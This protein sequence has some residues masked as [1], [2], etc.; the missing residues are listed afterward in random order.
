MSIHH[1]GAP[2]AQPDT[3]ASAGRG[4]WIAATAFLV[5]LTEQTALGFTLIAPALGPFAAKY[6]TTQIAWMIT[7]FILVAAVATPVLGKVADRIGKKR[8]LV[9]AGAIGFAGSVVC[10]L[11]PSYEVMLLGRGLMGV[12]GAFMPLAYA[13]IRDVFPESARNLSIGIVTNGVG[14]VTIAGPFLAGFLIDNVSLE[15]VFWFVAVISLVGAVGT[16]LVVPESPYRNAAPIDVPGFLG[17]AVGLLALM[18]GISNLATWTLSDSRTLLFVGGGLAILVAWWGWER[19]AAHP[20]VDTR[21][22]ASRPV[23]TVVFAYSF[24]TAA[25]TIASSYLPT[26]LQTPRALGGD[27]GFGL[28]ATGVA[29]YLIPAGILT[30]LAG[31][32]V[33]LAA[34]RYGFRVFLT[35]GAIFVVAG[36]LTLALL[37]TEPWMPM[38]GYGLIGL[39]SM[40]YA[41]GAGLLM[42]LAPPASRGIAAGML[43]AIAGAVGSA[44]AQVSGL[45]L[46]QNVGQL[47]QGFP[48]YTSSGWTNVFL[49]GACVA[50][51]GLLVS[52][53]VPRRPREVETPDSED[54]LVVTA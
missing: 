13:L 35:L 4:R 46:N 44:L 20:F 53:L 34:K 22:L 54:A 29:Q 39:G 5:L 9:M 48:V 40:V 41:A 43:S 28:D 37:H 50:G 49:I 21:L 15:S 19:R 45:V 30:V 18:Y 10:A 23:A 12:S 38:L 36:S 47:V 52:V 42:L 24:I 11:A 1:A 25:M 16:A 7:I 31:V 8:V 26:M 3:T 6:Q 2:G 32:I 14:V 27:Y 33:G 17:L 51:A